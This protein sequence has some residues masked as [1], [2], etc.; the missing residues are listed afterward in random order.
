MLARGESWPVWGGLRRDFLVNTR[1]I[2]GGDAKWLSTPP[3]KLWERPLGDGYS[4]I[5]EENGVLYT[6]YRRGASDVV[7]ALDALTGKTLWE[8]EYT[9][10]FTNA[11]SEQVG[12]GPYAMPQVI[13]Q[14]V[15]TASGIGRIHSLEKKTGKAAWSHD[16]YQEFGGTRLEFGYSSHALPYKDSLIVLAGGKQNAV[17]RLNQSD[18]SIVWKKHSFQNAHSSPLLIEVDGQPQVVALLAQ[19]VIGFD[20]ESGDMLWRHKHSTEYGLAISTVVWGPGNLLFVSSAYGA[21][22]RV[23]QLSRSAEVRE[24]WHNPRIQSHFG[25]VIRQG[26]HLYLSSGHRGPSFLTAVELRTGRVLWQARDFAKAQLLQADG[27]LIVLDEDGHLGIG[28]ASPEKFQAVAKWP[29]L[30]SLSWTPPTLV[31]TRLYMRDRRSIMAVDL[32]LNTTTASGGRV[33]RRE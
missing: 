7:I 4:P 3:K 8:F 2:P 24:L 20:P 1:G 31:G 33:T 9:A 29:L 13:G 30:T 14:R 12:P 32:G 18:G 23:L 11:Y 19:E 5:A 26:E 6:A 25:S 10:P 15:V 21:G 17:L 16:L 28:L 22:S 27:K